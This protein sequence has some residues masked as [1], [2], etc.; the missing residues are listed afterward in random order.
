MRASPFLAVS[1]LFV[2]LTSMKRD[3]LMNV[4]TWQIRLENSK[5]EMNTPGQE[6]GGLFYLK[7][8]DLT[9]HR[10]ILVSRYLCSHHEGGQ[11]AII[12]KD[13]KQQVLSVH[14]NDSCKWSFNAHLPM[15]ELKQNAGFM[16]GQHVQLYFV[17]KNEEYKI[18]DTVLLAKL[19]LKK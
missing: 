16:A 19:A 6:M 10:K 7:P 13:E 14:R 11:A 3:T 12:L 2:L 8:K 18:N 15:D 5:K 9:E 4:N 17:I 1:I